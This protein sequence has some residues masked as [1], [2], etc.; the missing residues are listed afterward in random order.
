MTVNNDL[1]QARL[2]TNQKHLTEQLEQIRI[3]HIGEDRREG[4]PFGKREEEATEAAEL[5]N[6][7]IGHRSP[8]I[9]FGDSVTA[10]LEIQSAVIGTG[11]R[12]SYRSTRHGA[13]ICTVSLRQICGPGKFTVT[14]W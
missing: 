9:Q 3:G 14:H 6:P 13:R 2:Q 1:L 4:S 12:C 5:V 7:P 10:H 11:R 8:A